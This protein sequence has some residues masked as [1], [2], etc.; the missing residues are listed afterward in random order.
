VNTETQSNG[1]EIAVLELKNL[2]KSFGG[3]QATRNVTLRIMPG[4]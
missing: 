2:C 4:G 1:G 3:L